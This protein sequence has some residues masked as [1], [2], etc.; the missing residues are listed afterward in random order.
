M[1][2]HLVPLL[3]HDLFVILCEKRESMASLLELPP[4]PHVHRT[5]VGLPSPFSKCPR[6][7]PPSF[8]DLLLLINTVLPAIFSYCPPVV[9]YFRNIIFTSSV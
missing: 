4:P 5:R 6:F 3:F 1:V 9:P 8:S 7:V 2:V